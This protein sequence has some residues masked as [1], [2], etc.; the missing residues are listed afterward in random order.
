M[1]RKLFPLLI[2]PALSLSSCGCSSFTDSEESVLDVYNLDLVDVP[3]YHRVTNEIKARFIKN[4][5]YVPYLTLKQYAS[6]YDSHLADGVES[7]F[8][9]KG[10]IVSWTVTANNVM[11]FF[12]QIDFDK[13]E[14]VTAG[15]L[16]STYKPADDTRDTTSLY[17]GNKTEYDSKLLGSSYFAHYS[18][19]NEEIKYFS[20]KGDYYLP[21]AF[22]DI[23]YC[24]DTSIYFY[25]NYHAIYS[26][27]DVEKFYT[28]NIGK[29]RIKSVVSEMIDYKDD[30]IAPSYVVDLNTNLFFYLLDN[31]YGLKQYKGIDSAVSYCQKIGTYKDL[32]SK[33]DLARTQAYAETL[34]RLDDNHTALVANSFVWGSQSY[35]PRQYGTGCIDRSSLRESLI[36]LRKHG[37]APYTH[38]YIND[39]SYKV[40]DDG[41]TGMLLFDE[42]KFGSTSEVFDADGSIE[43]D[44]GSYD[45]FYSL[46]NFFEKMKSTGTV[47]NIIIDVSTNGGGVLG[48]LMKL[49]ALISEDNKGCL[50]YLEGASQ[51][52]G[53][54]TTKVDADNNG[55]YD[56]RD[57]YGDDFNIY[58]LTSD[59]SF[60]CGNAFPCL[61]QKMGFAKIIGRKSGGGE[62]AVAVHYLPNGEYVYHSSNLHLG[63]YDE[64]SGVFTGFENGA[65]PD[66]PISDYNNFYS[67]NY[68]S[69]L[70]QNS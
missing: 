13:K 58:M 37:E 6:L 69:N 63:Y 49:L 26:S 52:L 50:Y 18:F 16:D 9:K 57:C 42:F 12:T 56:T 67:I 31:F 15:S 66:I 46:I 2:L 68:L 4:E 11:Y 62:C 1:N 28:V 24:F 17:Y 32:F 25:Y 55:T 3:V 41:K 43:K 33:N 51:Q 45:S 53:I 22:Y 61:A 10:K 59:C 19:S 70:I 8:S 21:L 14:V 47:E 39:G 44:A 38:S 65:Q 5:P 64:T 36:N 54:A 29:D 60:S 40:S 48:V 35:N 27:R 20:H 23:T 34:D 7:T 30:D